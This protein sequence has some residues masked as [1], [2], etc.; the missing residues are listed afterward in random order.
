FGWL[1]DYRPA[2]EVMILA[3]LTLL[4]GCFLLFEPQLFEPTLTRNRTQLTMFTIVYGLGF[5]GAF[6]MIQLVCVASFGQRELGK[7]LGFIVLC[8]TV[9]AVIGI[10]GIGFLKDLSGAYTVPFTI[11]TGVAV[12]GLL[13]MVFIRPLS[14]E[15]TPAA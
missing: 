10:A 6:T 14:A 1:A 7:I 9:G 13:N 5:G 4:A 3:S 2:K 15:K 8:D 12:I 11:V